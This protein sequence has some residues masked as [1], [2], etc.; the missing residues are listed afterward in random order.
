M[1]VFEYV[2]SGLEKHEYYKHNTNQQIVTVK[3]Q[4][5]KLGQWRC[6]KYYERKQ[7]GIKHNFTRELK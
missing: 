3:I 6:G 4:E 2:V 7:S 1:S 5:N